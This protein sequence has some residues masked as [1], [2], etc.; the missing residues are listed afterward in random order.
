MVANRASFHVCDMARVLE[1]AASG[2]YRWQRNRDRRSAKAREDGRL[3]GRLRTIH[4][5]S[6]RTYGEARLLQAMR[7]DGE[8]IGLCRLRRLMK[9]GRIRCETRKAYRVTTRRDSRRRP[10]PDLVRRSF[11]A[12][13]PNE[14][15]VAD[16][17]YVPTREGTLYLAI[18]MD[19]FSRRIVGYAM[20]ARQTS[21]LMTQA[22]R[23]AVTR[24]Q[25]SACLIHHSDQGSQYTSHDF[26]RQCAA[27]GIRQSMGSVGDC[28]DNAM[29]ESAF[30]TI[31]TELLDRHRFETRDAARRALI[32][33]IDGFYN[34]RRIHSSLDH[35]SP[36]EYER[37]HAEAA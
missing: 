35:R 8:S 10:A 22:L 2:F 37:H 19:A 23:Q 6:R 27:Y 7:R 31:E 17:T 32:Q 26:Q 14:L 9:E 13:R 24:R 15:W 18:V 33:Y 30:A 25:P 20:A 29:A 3:L 34:S 36:I 21:Q 1:V 5:E 4:V 11:R 28:Y 12:Q 16:A